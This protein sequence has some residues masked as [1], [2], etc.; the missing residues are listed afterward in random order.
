MLVYNGNYAN[1]VF[2]STETKNGIFRCQK[3]ICNKK[4]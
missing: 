1:E 2:Y 3:E 4:G